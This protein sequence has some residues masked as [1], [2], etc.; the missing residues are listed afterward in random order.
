MKIK[1]TNIWQFGDADTYDPTPPLRYCVERAYSKFNTFLE[2]NAKVASLPKTDL[3]EFI[4]LSEFIVDGVIKGPK[5]NSTYYFG[6]CLI[7]NE[8]SSAHC[9]VVHE[10]KI[11]GAQ[12]SIDNIREP[13]LRELRKYILDG[14][15]KVYD[16][17]EYFVENNI[18]ITNFASINDLEKCL[19]G[20]T[21]VKTA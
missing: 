17:K 10:I 19:R 7:E 14:Y 5:F 11:A 18:D 8:L 9:G 6:N 2:T 1:I 12:K 15:D 4:I 13:L 20:E 16:S 3:L 21:N